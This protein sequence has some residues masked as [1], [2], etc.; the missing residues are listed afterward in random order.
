MIY[1][2]TAPIGSGKTTALL[3]WMEKRNDVYGILTPVLNKSRVFVDAHTKEQFPMEA[4]GAEETILVGRFVFSKT[5]FEK[6]IQIIRN[7]I[8]KTGW[9]IIDEI[10]PLEL[11]GEGFHD[12]LKEVLAARNEKIVLVVREAMTELVKEY[13]NISEVSLIKNKSS[14]KKLPG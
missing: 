1:I 7:A 6:A 2:F 5:N 13:F 4:T 14:L 9:L 10:G 8:H 11:K 3:Q 12:V